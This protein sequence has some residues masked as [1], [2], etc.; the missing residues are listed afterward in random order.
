MKL[1]DQSTNVGTCHTFEEILPCLVGLSNEYPWFA[2]PFTFDKRI[3]EKMALV[4]ARYY[5]Q[6]LEKIET[7]LTKF[8]FSSQQVIFLLSILF[9]I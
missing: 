7:I 5:Q 2:F 8:D 4:R 6:M 9:S 1:L 3:I